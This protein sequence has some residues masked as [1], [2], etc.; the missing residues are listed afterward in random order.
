MSSPL[1]SKER[2]RRIARA[3]L[4]KEPFCRAC[5]AEGKVTPARIADHIVAWKG[6]VMSFWQSPLQS[7][8]LSCHNGR[9]Q[10]IERRGFDNAIGPDGW[11]LD[12]K[13]PVYSTRK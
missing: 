6:D 9:K 2:W 13:H 8:C 5:L 10:F 7:L 12:P 3:Q 11:P 4:N 1:Y